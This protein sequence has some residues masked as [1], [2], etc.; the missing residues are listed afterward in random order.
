MQKNSQMFMFGD[1]YGKALDDMI[2]PEEATIDN[3][4][5]EGGEVPS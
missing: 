3:I 1:A 5:I 2:L 4:K